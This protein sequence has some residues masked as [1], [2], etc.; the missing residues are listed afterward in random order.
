MT[1]TTRPSWLPSIGDILFLLVLYLLLG[2]LPDFIFGDGS[3]GWHFV[4]GQYILEHGRVPT[5]D[6]VSYTFASKE[7][8]AYEWLFDAFI[9]GL[10]KIGGLRLV[11]VACCSA[12]SFMFLLLYRDCRRAG[13][14]YGLTLVLCIM[15]A[16]V[17]AIHWLARPH[18]VTWFGV[19]LFAKLLSDFYH[20]RISAGK[21]WL[22]LA[23]TMLIWVNCHP[24]FL[25]GFAILFIY[26]FCDLFAWAGM[27]ASEARTKCG[28]RLKALT[29][30]G[31]I[32]G[33][34]SLINPYGFK[35]YQYIFQ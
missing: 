17:S 28:T 9:A 23:L 20:E 24:A 16:F 12:I 35:L 34:V 31:A 21:L 15:G 5:V 26:W 3:T 13:C 22:F 6:L 30:S 33:A 4:A 27:A 32:V 18:L 19:Y 11:S 1:E 14:H 29:I 25:M 2:L 7:W 10:E 8:V